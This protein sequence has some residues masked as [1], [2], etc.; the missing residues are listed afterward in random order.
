M[1]GGV[2][3]VSK[4]V[5]FFSIII[6]SMDY[7]QRTHDS[8]LLLA[9]WHPHRFL[10]SLHLKGSISSLASP[11]GI[12]PVPAPKQVGR[13]L[14][15]EFLCEV[16]EVAQSCPTLCHPM[17]CSL[18]GYSVHGIFQARILE[19]VAISFSEGSSRP[20]DR[21]RVYCIV[22]RR[23]TVWATREAQFSYSLLNKTV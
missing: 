17:D 20:R 4:P 11:S 2:I 19:W 16:S 14:H 1:A 8:P 5:I 18:P 21:T 6:K 7:V 22:G 3:G 10:G 13:K 12:T 15:S 9:T 23:F